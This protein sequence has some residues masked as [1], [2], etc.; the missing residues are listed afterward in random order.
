MKFSKNIQGNEM[1]AP[2]RALR[3]RE[4]TQEAAVVTKAVRRT[5][6]LLGIK[7]ANLGAIL[8][9]SESTASRLQ[10]GVYQLKSGSKEME[11]AVLL[12]RVFRGLDAIVGGDEASMQSW[13]VSNNTALNEI[14]LNLLKT[15]SGINDVVAYVDARRARI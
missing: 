4:V 14:P 15:I 10:N 12:I 8:G 9:L 6:Q 7:N 2:G 13:I 11:L 1:V 5:A 3:L